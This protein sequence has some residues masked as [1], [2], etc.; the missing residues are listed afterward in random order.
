MYPKNQTEQLLAALLDVCEDAVLTISADGRVRDRST[1]AARLYGYSEAEILG[2]PFSTLLPLYELPAFERV[3]EDAASG[4]LERCD[5]SE[6]LCRGGSRIVVNVKRTVVRSAHHEAMLIVE[7]GRESRHHT[8]KN[9]D[10][11]LLPS[12]L[13]DLPVVLWTTDRHLRVTSNWGCGAGTPRILPGEFVGKTV[14]DLLKYHEPDGT[15]IV[16]HHNALR[17]VASRFE[18]WMEDRALDIQ[19]GP[20]RT[21]EGE[22]VGVSGVALDITERKKLEDDARFQATHDALTGLANYR[23]FL[24]ILEREVRRADRSHRPFAVLLLDLDELKMINDRFGHLAGN[25]ALKRLAAAMKESSRAT[26][27]AARYGGDEFALLL[28]DTDPG[29]AEQV[30]QRIHASLRKDPELPALSVSIGAAISP[31]DG[32]SVQEL[33]ETADQ[34]LY[35]RKRQSRAKVV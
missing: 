17:G 25:R 2:K 6:R 29:M 5:T 23:E 21:P 35:R 30:A 22:I 19:V 16:H 31:A 1:G 11:A 32:R 20:L 14:F 33:L 3:L 18:Y 8:R 34:R 7:T 28:I 10:N 26:D 4:D 24:N 27:L 15:P 9:P 12:Q 13:Q